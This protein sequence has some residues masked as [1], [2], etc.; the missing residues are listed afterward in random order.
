MTPKRQ[1][2]GCD[3]AILVILCLFAMS[4]RRAIRSYSQK[5]REKD[6]QT[7]LWTPLWGGLSPLV[8]LGFGGPFWG[9]NRPQKGPQNTFFGQF[10]LFP[11]GYPRKWRKWPK[12][13]A[14]F[15]GFFPKTSESFGKKGSKTGPGTVFGVPPPI[16]S[17]IAKFYVF[18]S[19]FCRTFWWAK[20]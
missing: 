9:Q 2:V 17:F 11:G 15:R 18:L 19:P 1:E 3:I 14:F 10:S 6:P 7:L 12:K 13:S 8:D 5:N 4:Q 20:G 16:L